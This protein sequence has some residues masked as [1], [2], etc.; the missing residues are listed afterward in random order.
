MP[1]MPDLPKMNNKIPSRIVIYPRD[2]QNITGCRER[3]ARH[4]LQ[5]IRIANNK[6]PD[7]FVTIAEFCAFRG[8]K[9]EDVRQFL[10]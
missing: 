4:I 6:S 2:V 7:H 5:Q 8:L 3:T 9:E 10:V 1:D